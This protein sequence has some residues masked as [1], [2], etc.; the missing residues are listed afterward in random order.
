MYIL[1]EE[2]R[3]ELKKPLGKLIK[4]EK[5][6]KSELEGKSGLEII[7]IG[8]KVSETLLKLGMKPKLVIYDKRIMRNYVGTLPEILSYEAT[9]VK[10]ENQRGTISDEALRAIKDAISSKDRIKIEVQGEEDLLTLIAIH[11]SNND[12]LVF[13]GQPNEGIVMIK[14]DAEIKEKVKSILRCMENG[15]KD[16]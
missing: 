7:T 8:D 5:E 10:V 1:P 4:D 3:K 6:L 14:V 9:L 13:Y 15:D 16:N 2:L 11:F 12:T